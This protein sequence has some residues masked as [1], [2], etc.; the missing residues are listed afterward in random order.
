M[1]A[2]RPTAGFVVVNT[3]MLWLATAVAS[4]A[5]WP[6]YRSSQLIYVVAITVVVG[7]LIAILGAV[8]RWAAPIVLG[9]TVLAFFAFGV[10]LA[11]PAKSA[12]GVLPT[13]GGLLDLTSGVAL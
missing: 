7:S 11:V 4:V 12:F 9:A 13:A 6:V 10:P 2:A 5:L 8:F 1:K 3:L